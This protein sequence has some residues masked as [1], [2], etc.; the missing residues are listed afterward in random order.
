[1]YK[2]RFSVSISVQSAGVRANDATPRTSLLFLKEGLN[3]YGAERATL[4]LLA[5]L[6]CSRFVI[7]VVVLEYQ[8]EPSEFLR[9]LKTIPGI[10]QIHV[11]P[12]RSNR[13]VREL[14]TL[15]ESNHFDVLVPIGYKLN[16]LSLLSSWGLRSRRITVL[17]SWYADTWR[18]RLYTLLDRLLLSTFDGIFGV[19]QPMLDSACAYVERERLQWLGNS[20]DIEHTETQAS[21]SDPIADKTRNQLL[22]VGRLVPIKNIPLLL[23]AFARLET[24]QEL[25]LAGDGPQRKALEALAE[26]LGIRDRVHFLGHVQ[27]PLPLMAS[28]AAIVL[29]SLSEGLPIV[30]LEAM[31]L[32]KCLIASPVGDLPKLILHRKTGLLS[33]SGDIEALREN[34]HA[35]LQTPDL[36]RTLGD[37]ARNRVRTHFA[38][39]SVADRFS[40]TLTQWQQRW[41]KRN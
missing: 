7:Q 1:M 17:H 24:S 5:N 16:I 13:T 11:L 39:A 38:A 22:F 35:V 9:S 41:P 6:D 3:N 30:A 32:G 25:F 40:E 21:I 26:S 18:L 36:R 28:C 8:D 27:N 20:I 33:P 29:P 15:C 2:Q 34:M 4:S 14:R 37:A 31:A 19:S 12:G 10:D 23:G